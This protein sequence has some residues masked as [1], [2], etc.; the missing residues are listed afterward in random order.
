MQN[1][2]LYRSQTDKKIAG[3][4]GGLAEY[5]N[6]D[7]TIVRLLLVL[8]VLLGGAGVLLYIIAWILMPENNAF[9]NAGQNYNYNY[10]PDGANQNYNQNDNGGNI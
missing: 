8:F 2:K 3:V 4:C 10:N 1:K 6:I 5:F 9:N 7:S